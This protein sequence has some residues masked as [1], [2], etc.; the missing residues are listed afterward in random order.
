MWRDARMSAVLGQEHAGR[1]RAEAAQLYALRACLSV[2]ESGAVAYPRGRDR[3]GDGKDGFR[4]LIA[5]E[6]AFLP[7]LANPLV[8]PTVVALLGANLHLLSSHLIA[9]PPLAAG[10]PRRIRTPERHGWHR[11]IYR[12]AHDLGDYQVP[13]MALKCAYY[14]TDVGDPCSGMTMFLPGS[15]R[16][17]EPLR[18]PPGQIDPPGAVTPRVGPQDAVLFENRTWHA[19]GVNSCGRVRL[20]VML[21]YGYRWLARVDDPYDET[22]ASAALDPVSRQLL[23]EPDRNPDGSFAKGRGARAI[24]AWWQQLATS[25]ER[26]PGA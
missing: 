13:R 16:R 12:A 10:A 22:L 1:A 19:G 6:P 26:I 4:G 25:P 17:R 20:A 11:D 23:G 21:H 3:G 8:L 15:H 24:D 5:L 14:L 2:R 7:L 18:V 9:L